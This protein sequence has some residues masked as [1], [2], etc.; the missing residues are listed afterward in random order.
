MGRNRSVTSIPRVIIQISSRLLAT[1]RP[2]SLLLLPV[3]DSYWG[4]VDKAN[5]FGVFTEQPAGDRLFIDAILEDRPVSPDFY[6]GL[7]VQEVI[8]AALRAHHN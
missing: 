3:P 4:N 2:A 7:K 1:I 6:D 8:D 5:P